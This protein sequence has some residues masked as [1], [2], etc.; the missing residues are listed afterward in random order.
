MRI[1]SLL[2][3]AAGLWLVSACEDDVPDLRQKSSAPDTLVAEATLL[4]VNQA[5]QIVRGK[6]VFW[7]IDSTV[8]HLKIDVNDAWLGGRLMAVHIHQGGAENPGMHFNA[9]L[10]MQQK[11]CTTLS[12]NQAWGKPY[13]GDVGNIKTNDSGI[14]EYEIST[15][16]WSIHS[17]APANS[18]LNRAVVI[19]YAPTDFE[20]ECDPEHV[21]DH[22]HANPEYAIGNIKLLGLRSAN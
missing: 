11:A 5:D 2:F 10:P 18:I 15:D 19:H 13:I 9:G 14:G 6:A 3:F 1:L 7:T 21:P 22:D 8:V 17:N 16:L 20:E 12:L 4:Q